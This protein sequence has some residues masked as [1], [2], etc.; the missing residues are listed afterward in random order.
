LD[1]TGFANQKPEAPTERCARP[2]RGGEKA[3]KIANDVKASCQDIA[4]QER[5][6]IE[7]DMSLVLLIIPARYA[8]PWAHEVFATGFFVDSKDEL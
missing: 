6:Q 5:M 7:V 8:H 2:T 3:C 1:G 4:E